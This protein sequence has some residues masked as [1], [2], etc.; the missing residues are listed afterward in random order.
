MP[1]HWQG[2]TR[3]ARLPSDWPARKRAVRERDRGICW[4]CGQPGADYVDHKNPGDDH[5]LEN[6]AEVHDK[7]WPHCHRYKS[8]AEG[9]RA[10][11][12]LSNKRPPE[13]HPGLR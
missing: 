7:A 5:S 3:S 6:L 13:T 11:V 2:S 4:I 10:R 1:G 12:R 8:S 9:N